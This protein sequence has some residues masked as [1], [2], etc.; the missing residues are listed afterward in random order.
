MTSL[1]C[2]GLPRPPELAGGC[3]MLPRQGAQQPLPL[4]GRQPPGLGVM[5][6]KSP[7][8]PGQPEGGVENGS[9]R[10]QRDACSISFLLTTSGPARASVCLSNPPPPPLAGASLATSWCLR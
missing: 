8:G 2:R 10:Q 3:S 6:P 7:P 1:G 4:G 5:A 9:G